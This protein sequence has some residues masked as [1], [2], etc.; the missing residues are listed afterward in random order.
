MVRSRADNYLE[1][2]QGILDTAA[3]MFAAHGFNGTSIST[4]AEECGI[5]KALL[6]HYYDSKEKLLYEMLLVHC[7]LLANVAADAAKKSSEPEQQLRDL[8][9][10]LMELYVNSR[11]KHVVLLND[12][13]CLPEEQQHQIKLEERRVLQVMK[14]T[15][16]RLTPESKAAQLTALT[17]YLMGAINW[18]YTWFRTPGTVSAQEYADLATT[19]FLHG[20]KSAAIA[21]KGSPLR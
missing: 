6:Y 8:V 1:R 17:M 5:S 19:T 10:A 11:D 14:S 16:K 21:E 4:L 12:L 2:Q 7:K 15:I 3:S 18:T 9:R 20:L 13:H